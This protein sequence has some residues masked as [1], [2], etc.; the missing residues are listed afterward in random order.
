M[1]EPRFYGGLGAHLL[2]IINM[3]ACAIIVVSIAAVA[4]TFMWRD[5][6]VEAAHHLLRA[7]AA[8]A[9]TY[10]VQA[11]SCSRSTVSALQLTHNGPH[12]CDIIRAG[13]APVAL[14]VPHGQAGRDKPLQ[15]NA[16]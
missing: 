11:T 2:N 16:C 6:C 9:W 4:F 12:A 7:H 10:V 1:A 13:R 8:A 5:L 15:R 14:H 3:M